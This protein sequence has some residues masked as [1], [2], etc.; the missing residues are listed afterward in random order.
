MM[1]YSKSLCERIAK[2]RKQRGFTQEQLATR[3]GITYQAVSKWENEQSCPD[4]SLL[5]MIAEVFQISLDEL[6]GIRKKGVDLRRGLIAEYLF[7]GDARDTGGYEHHGRVAGASL[8]EDRFGN[9][10]SAYYFNGKDSYIVVDSAPQVNPDAFSLSVWCCYGANSRLDGWGHAIVSQ[11]GHHGRRVFQLSTLDSNITFHRFLTETDL[12]EAAPLHKGYW[13]HIA[14]T[15]E[16]QKFKLYRNG[17]MVCEQKGKLN[18]AP[19]E[20]LYMG[21]KSTDEPY[22]FFQGKIDD[23]RMYNRALSSDEVNELF[24]DNDWVPVKEPDRLVEEEK[25]LPVLDCLEDIQMAVPETHIHAA[26]E[27]YK[28]HL[29]F[30][31]LMEHK[32]Q[33]YMLSLYR[34]PNLLLQSTLSYTGNAEI[35]APFIFKTRR[36]LEELMEQWTEAG[37][38][39]QEVRDEGFAIFVNFRDPFGHNWTVMREKR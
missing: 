19:D 36:P 9:P 26:A 23:I 24:L 1:N 15:Y 7:D 13:Y 11:D 39:V 17:V 6:F 28:S 3:L 33:F 12:A 14:I 29:G 4:V 27:W 31:T 30:K 22:F 32:D 38:S 8:C 16:D 10:D 2:L 18:P 5:P 20:P 35:F 21:R 25:D 34:G 37:A